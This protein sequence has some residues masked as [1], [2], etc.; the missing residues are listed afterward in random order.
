M[1]TFKAGDKVRAKDTKDNRGTSKT[2]PHLVPGTVSIVV[3]ATSQY[4]YFNDEVDGGWYHDR[5]ELV[6]EAPQAIPV[7]IPRPSSATKTD[8]VLSYLLSG[9]TLT[10]LEAIS[11]FSLFRLSSVVL[12]LRRQ[13]HNIK[14]NLKVDVNGTE[15]AEYALVSKKLP[16]AA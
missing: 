2:W 8:R 10:Q 4:V 15:Y 11:L 9:K 13:G 7:A 5:F 6:E 16:R 12:N 1:S 14:T 3:K